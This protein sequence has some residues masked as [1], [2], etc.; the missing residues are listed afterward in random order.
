MARLGF[1]YEQAGDLDRAREAYKEAQ[2]V[3]P[4]DAFRFFELGHIYERQHDWK[5]AIYYY[6]RACDLDS[7][8]GPQFRAKLEAKTTELRNLLRYMM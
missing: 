5:Q 8:F 2:R 6:Q 4:Q 1:L 7:G 3:E